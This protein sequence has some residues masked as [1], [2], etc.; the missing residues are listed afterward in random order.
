[1]R[2]M[3]DADEEAAIP[4]LFKGRL[5]THD[6]RRWSAPVHLAQPHCDDD[7]YRLNAPR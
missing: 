6:P 4:I 3:L 7:V 1:M 2:H 5:R